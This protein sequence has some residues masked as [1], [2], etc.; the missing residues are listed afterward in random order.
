MLKS[1]LFVD[2]LRCKIVRKILK[3]VI[4]CLIIK[5]VSEV[6]TLF[7]SEQ[8]FFHQAAEALDVFS[9]LAKVKYKQGNSK[10]RVCQ[11]NFA[12]MTMSDTLKTLSGQ[13]CGKRRR[14]SDSKSV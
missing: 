8:R 6:K 10:Q 9:T 3:N 11:R 7:Q 12:K 2:N 5:S 4:I 13:K 14:L 1:V